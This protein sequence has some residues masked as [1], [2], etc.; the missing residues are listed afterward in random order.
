[1]TAARGG[2][3]RVRS[4]GMVQS[5]RADV[6]RPRSAEEV[7]SL[8]E[9]ARR[10]GR[11]VG[12][13]GAGCSYGDASLAD[14]ALLLDTT[15][16]SRILDWNPETGILRAEPGATIRQCWQ[17]GLPDG[18]W[19]PVV[20]GT[21]EVTLGGAAAMN[22]HGKNSFRA[23]SFG[24]HVRAFEIMLAGGERRVCS[25]EENAEL[26]HAAI[27]SFGVLGVFTWIEL[28]MKRI[29]S[30]LLEVV[31][32]AVPSFAETFPLFESLA[33]DADYLVG[34]HDGFASGP[35]TGR[36]LLHAARHLDDPEANDARW[37]DLERQRLPARLFGV[38]PRS[39]IWP[40]LWCFLHD[41]GMRLVNAL[42]FRSGI[43]HAR[44][45]A[46]RQ[47]HAAYHFLLDYVPNWKYAYRPGGL[48][49]FQ[50][51]LPAD[52]A[53]EVFPELIAR[54]RSG[55]VTP[56]LCVTKRHRRDGFLLSYAPDGYSMALDLRVTPGRRERVWALTAELEELVLSRGGRFYFAKDSVLRPENLRRN[57]DESS[58]L[59]FRELKSDL[60]PGGILTSDLYRRVFAPTAP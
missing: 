38:F 2:S 45:G 53:R 44:R 32:H 27:G 28:R 9:E 24:D 54:L 12:L 10:T 43:R 51:F 8:L 42:K 59:R 5:C 16:F 50:P 4:W 22:I 15:A 1:M 3:E 37:F 25:R 55:G 57:F 40:G 52:A 35:S 17:R 20:S 26:F 31:P 56:Y 29:A 49:Q 6:R 11:P 46:Y 18:W 23:G 34:W 14:G 47:A 41:P 60:D 7:S 58:L 33:P 30:G 39:W 21:M 36:G 19:P 48:I 13:R